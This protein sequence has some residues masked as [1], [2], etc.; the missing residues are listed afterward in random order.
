M[1]GFIFKR[2]SRIPYGGNRPSL[3]AFD[4]VFFRNDAPANLSLDF[5]RNVE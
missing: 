5:A 3:F 2:P 1:L 4:N